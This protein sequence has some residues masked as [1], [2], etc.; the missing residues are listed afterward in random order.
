MAAI[1]PAASADGGSLDPALVDAALRCVAR[2]GV[3]KTTLDDLARESRL[4]RA[5]IYRL[6]PGGREA[7]VAGV[8]A[9]E[10]ARFVTVVGAAVGEC[11]DAEDA[12][13]AAITSAARH[14]NGHD[15]LQFL[16]A[17]EPGFVLP[18]L[19]FHALDELLVRAA[20][21]GGRML[22]P[23]V[24]SNAEAEEL[25]EWIGRILVSHI[26]CPSAGMQLTDDASVRRLVRAFVLPGLLVPA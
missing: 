9:A 10:V 16:L 11:V 24:A 23:F 25:A 8:V 21:I 20:E 6:A 2:W 15:A 4:S 26:C 12:V 1:V 7:M 22:A 14:L 5:T 17:H 13:V 18:H 19:A 3:A